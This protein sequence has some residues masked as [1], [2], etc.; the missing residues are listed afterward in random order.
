MSRKPPSKGNNQGFG[1]RTKSN[2]GIGNRFKNGPVRLSHTHEIDFSG[3]GGSSNMLRDQNA[4][5]ANDLL[6]NL[7]ET[8]KKLSFLKI[9]LTRF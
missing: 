8:G 4:R 5:K 2:P 7:L 6:G 3:T 9:H 1:P